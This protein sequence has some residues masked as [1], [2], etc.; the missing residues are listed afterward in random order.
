MLRFFGRI[1]GFV[2]FNIKIW[3]RQYE[4]EQ[5]QTKRHVYSQTTAKNSTECQRIRGS[6]HAIWYLLSAVERLDSSPDARERR[7][8][9]D[10]QRFSVVTDVFDARAAMSGSSSHTRHVFSVADA[11]GCT[12][13]KT[14]DSENLG[15]D[16]QNFLR[17]P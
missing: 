12:L 9:R 17:R 3:L 13:D 14:S 8:F 5:Q 4:N 16:F 15:P 6:R 10:L 2:L 11:N 7:K 1:K